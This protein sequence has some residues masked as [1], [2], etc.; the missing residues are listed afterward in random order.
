MAKA[1]VYTIKE[2]DLRR[3]AHAAVQHFR[4]MRQ[5]E[6]NLPA[7]EVHVEKVAREIESAY[8]VKFNVVEN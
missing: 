3:V 8:R 1:A 6:G 7:S 5:H 4:V 2:E